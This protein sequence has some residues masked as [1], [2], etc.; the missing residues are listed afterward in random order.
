M[1]ASGAGA[2][3]G[4]TASVSTASTRL[5]PLLYATAV[6]LLAGLLGLAGVSLLRADAQSDERTRTEHLARARADALVQ[7]ATRTF[8]IVD[9]LHGQFVERD[10]LVFFDDITAQIVRIDRNTSALLYAPEGVLIRRSPAEGWGPPVGHDLLADPA[11]APALRRAMQQRTFTVIPE[12]RD[13]V[14]ALTA[15]LP[16][17]TPEVEGPQRFWGFIGVTAA[18][19]GLLSASHFDRIA[20]AGDAYRLVHLTAEAPSLWAGDSAPLTD[21]VIVPVTLPSLSLRLELAPVEGWRTGGPWWMAA[22]AVLLSAALLGSLAYGQFRR[23]ELLRRQV[24]LRT[25]QLQEQITERD[26]AET[27]LAVAEQRLRL[28]VANAPVVIFAIDAQGVFT[29]SEGLGLRALGRASGEV[30]G[31]SIFE[32]YADQPE[33]IAHIKRALAGA[34]V[35]YTTEIGGAVY[36]T[37]AVPVRDSDGRVTGVIGFPVDVTERVRAEQS[38]QRERDFAIQ[39]MTAMGQGLTVTDAEGHFTFVNPA[40]ARLVG[41]PAE[42]LIGRSPFDF[43]SA[44]DQQ[45][46]ARAGEQRRRGEITTYETALRRPDGEEVQVLITGVPLQRNGAHAGSIAVVTDLTERREAEEALRHSEERYRSVV[47]SVRDV[48]FQMDLGGRW[49]FLNPAWT[50]VTG[51]PVAEALGTSSAQ[52]IHP[53]DRGLLAR[54]FAQLAGQQ[55]ESCRF[56]ARCRTATGAVRWVEVQAQLTREGLGVPSGIA[57]VFSDITDRK[58]AQEEI[59]RRERYLGAVAEVE[60][61]LLSA[62]DIQHATSEVLGPLGGATGADRVYVFRN[63]TAPHGALLCSQVAEWCAPGVVAQLDNPDLRDVPYEEMVPRWATVLADGGVISGRVADFPEM[64]RAVLEPQGII[65]ILV[66]PLTVHGRFWGFIGFDDTVSERVWTSAEVALLRTAAGALSLAHEQALVQ[67]ELR[68]REALLQSVVDTSPVIISLQD[69]GGQVQFVS[70][71]V[72]DLLGYEP[73]TWIGMRPGE[74][75]HPDEWEMAEQTFQQLLTSAEPQ[76]VRFRL[77]HA[78][79]HWV[80]LECHRRLLPGIDGRPA[81]VISASTDVTRQAEMEQ[82]REQAREAAEEANRAKSDFLSRMSHE[83]RTPLNAILGFAQL[84]EMDT[85]T[86]E[87]EEGVQHI[88][89]AGQHLLALINE[90]L[91]ISRIEAGRLALTIEPVSVSEMVRGVVDLMAPLAA[92]RDIRI[93]DQTAKNG[94]LRVRADQQRLKQV[95][96]NLMSNAVKYNRTGGSVTVAATPAPEGQVRIAVTDTGEGIPAES[97]S[98]LFT[99]FERLGADARAIEG[100]GVGLA[101]T[102]RLVDFMGGAAGVES[103][104]GIGSTFWFTLPAGTPAAAPAPALSTP[105]EPD[106]QPEVTAAAHRVLYVEDNPANYKLVER[107]LASRSHIALDRADCG[108]A[109]VEQAHARR[110][111]LILLDLNLPDISGR[112]V[113]GRLRASTTT[114]DIPVVIVSADSSPGQADE[115]CRAGAAAYLTKP[116]DIGTFLR[117]VDHHVPGKDDRP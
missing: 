45:T 7:E 33:I 113:L 50:A 27:S 14:T 30:A 105:E 39:V 64:E 117:T 9:A 76:T 86:L 12:T 104:L 28:V 18:L 13:G 71:A 68:E 116:L 92:N 60:R 11:L 16:A 107:V 66:L 4:L 101:L 79:G 48:I 32:V 75:I 3:W 84:M 94:A 82:A 53:E 110:P 25:R 55:A 35:A 100:T 70:S 61:I 90:I 85:L 2:M 115:L 49:T 59:E 38:A 8:T 31:R 43:T 46:L 20:A 17:W 111:D 108:Y 91:D 98:K 44:A 93:I 73:V 57:G 19:P 51:F 78:A 87:Q 6:F 36:D 97:L 67:T 21:P 26:R 63:H 24:A 95:L 56:E 99:P 88:I 72:T 103:T 52:V 62:E 22:V 58:L 29:L 40:Y 81:M 42:R 96:L 34:D 74:A 69:L 77:R 47:E 106:E 65:S 114:K 41:L 37:R 109:G 83:L 1:A 80:M 112:E 23:P 15:W 89:G 5:R 54:Q 10:L 102:K